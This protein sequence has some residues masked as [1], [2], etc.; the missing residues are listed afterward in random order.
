MRSRRLVLRCAQEGGAL[1][2]VPALVAQFGER[3]ALQAER[4]GEL[5]AMMEVVR[6]DVPD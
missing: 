1:G 3:D 5:A 6:E 4:E 2:E